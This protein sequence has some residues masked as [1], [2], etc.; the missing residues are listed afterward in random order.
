MQPACGINEEDVI[1]VLFRLLDR[2]KDDCRGITIFWPRNNVNAV[3][4]GPNFQLVGRS[5]PEDPRPEPR[6]QA[7]YD[8]RACAKYVA[9][10]ARLLEEYMA[11]H[12]PKAR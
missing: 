2:I 7:Y 9:T 3:P 10:A 4:L 8:H 11:E 12:P 6:T 5:G 1:I